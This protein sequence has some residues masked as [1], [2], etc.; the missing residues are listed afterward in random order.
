MACYA[1][2]AQDQL[3]DM[4]CHSTR[5]QEASVQQ[6]GPNV[7]RLVPALQQQWDHAA[8]AHLGPVDIKPYSG[9]KVWWICEQCPDG[10]LHRWEATVANRSNGRGCP[11]CTGRI[12]CK[13]NSL[14]TKAPAVAA[15]WDYEAN[16]DTPD[17]VVAHSNQAVGWVCEVCGEKWSATPN[18]RVTKKN[19]TGCPQCYENKRGK[20]YIRHPSFAECQDPRGKACLAEWDHE[21]NAANRNFPHNTRLYSNKKIFWLCSKCPAGQQHSWSA[22][23]NQR[24]GRHNS[25]CPFCAGHAACRCNSLQ[26]LYPAIAT[27]WD[28]AKNQSQPSDHT[29]GS[30]DVAWWSK[31]QCG[32]W[33]QSINSR[34]TD[35]RRSVRSKQIRK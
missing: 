1:G 2:R 14:A 22:M 10:H 11:Q 5:D 7:S 3:L 34:T 26:A 24:S 15:Q 30:H 35:V 16:A 17:N 4:R 9:R 20:N 21:R 31:P 13:H 23:P 27:E 32:S 28:Y 25:G 29:A 8:N 18:K 12:V 6:K 33:K 19:K